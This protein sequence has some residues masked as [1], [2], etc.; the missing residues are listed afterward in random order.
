MPIKFGDINSTIIEDGSIQAD[1][2]NV[3]S[4]DNVNIESTSLYDGGLRFNVG[5][6]AQYWSLTSDILN[7]YSIAGDTARNM[8]LN[9]NG[10]VCIIL[11]TT[12]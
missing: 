7:L 5:D 3:G 11:D 2:I 4:N 6:P 1:K 12:N 10:G 9:F 8:Y